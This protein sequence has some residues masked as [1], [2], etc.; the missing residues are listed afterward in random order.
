MIGQ[1]NMSLGLWVKCSFLF[2]RSWIT[3]VIVLLKQVIYF[4]TFFLLV[5]DEEHSGPSWAAAA[6]DEEDDEDPENRYG[7]KSPEV[8]LVK[9]PRCG[10]KAM[11]PKLC[12][13]SSSTCVFMTR[14]RSN[15]S[16]PKRS[17]S[18]GPSIK[19]TP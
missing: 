2:T 7:S 3:G 15:Q 18:R 1:V 8:E 4:V 17:C 9:K 13:K 5:E 16:R 12:A 19:Y 14:L 10:K 11:K 6:E